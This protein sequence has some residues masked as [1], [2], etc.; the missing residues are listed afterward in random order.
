MTRK[1][2]PRKQGKSPH[3]HGQQRTLYYGVPIPPAKS[4]SASYSIRRGTVQLVIFEFEKN[5]VYRWQLAHRGL[6]A[7]EILPPEIAELDQVADA[8]AALQDAQEWLSRRREAIADLRAQYD[9]RRLIEPEWSRRALNKRG[10]IDSTLDTATTY[11]EQKRRRYD[12]S[13]RDAVIFV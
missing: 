6:R 8:I 7:Y 1:R 5:G 9:T 12:R 3:Q 10:M 4:L 2:E 13:A 11:E